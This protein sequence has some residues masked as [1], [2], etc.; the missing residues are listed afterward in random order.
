V[1]SDP[2]DAGPGRFDS[3]RW[4]TLHQ[5][6]KEAGTS[7][8]TVKGWLLKRLVP[9]HWIKGNPKIHGPDLARFLDRGGVAR[10]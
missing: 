8:D 9:C 7:V 5:A 3:D 1:T 2:T 6:A 10:S 4:F